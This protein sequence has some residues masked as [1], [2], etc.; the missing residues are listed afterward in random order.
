[1]A[2]NLNKYVSPAKPLPIILL[3]DTSGSMKI[4]DRIGKLNTAVKTMIEEFKDAVQKEVSIQ[5]AIVSFS[6][7]PVLQL[8]YTSPENI[9]YKDL[10]ANGGTELGKAL[11]FVKEMIEDKEITPSRAY[12]PLVVLVSDGEPFPGWESP[13]KNFIDEGRS[14]KC[15]RMSMFIG[16]EGDNC[17][18]VKSVMQEFLRNTSNEV[19]HAKDASHITDFF[20][21]VTMSTIARTKSQNPDI[22]IPLFTES[23]VTPNKEI[24][25]EANVISQTKPTVTIQLEDRDNSSDS[26]DEIW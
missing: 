21:F 17:E 3:L 23:N 15:D 7:D 20:K 11:N 25:V 16:P 14:A 10:D 12:R 6:N 5:L 1:M 4:D 24:S 22:A 9:K 2:F 8:S 19:F 26:E 13:M 18:A